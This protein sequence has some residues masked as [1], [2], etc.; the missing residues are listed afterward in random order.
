MLQLCCCALHSFLRWFIFLH[1]Y[2]L[3]STESVSATFV[4]LKHSYSCDGDVLLFGMNACFSLGTENA[5]PKKLFI[6]IIF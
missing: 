1:R 6:A 5:F 2:A 3:F 4:C